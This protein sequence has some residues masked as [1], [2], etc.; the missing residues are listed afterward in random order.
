MKILYITLEDLS[1]HKGS[2][3][4]IKEI[5][6]GFRKRGHQVGLIGSS[7]NRSENADYFY[8]LK[9]TDHFF[10]KWLKNRKQPLFISSITLFLYLLRVLARYDLIYARD[11]H[12]VI[13][14]LISRFI[15]GKKL[16]FEI[17]GIAH[18]EQRLKGDT[19]LNRIFVFLIK[20]AE[21]V[22]SNYSDR[23]VSVTPQIA[24]Y[25]VRH[26]HTNKDKIEFISNGVNTRKF[27][28]IHDE[29]ILNRKR[30]ELGITVDEM[31]ITFVGN[32][33]PW[34]GVDLLIKAAPLVIEKIKSLKFLI[35]GDG[36]LR[37]EYE[38][39]VKHLGL[40]S[41]IIFTGMLEYELIPLI[42]NLSDI[43]VL[44]KRSMKSGFSPIKLYE[45]MACGKPILASRVEGM[46][47]IEEEG[48]GR[49]AEPG[50]VMDFSKG[51]IELLKD[52]KVRNEMGQKGLCLA[53]NRYDWN[54]KV[55]EIENIM[56]KLV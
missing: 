2:V 54:N 56:K 21:R 48:I 38:Q 14:S 44:P 4:H 6:A 19:I 45:Y 7:C 39:E 53:R 55:V 22:A 25:L 30:I 12:T 51:L 50:D 49:L 46:K 28:P 47:L 16:I 8:N 9:N 13:I 27:Y 5:I 29:K 35:V 40:T 34:Q 18:E 17:N 31:V 1:L 42:I 43:C 3:I 36:I 15:Y 11:F 10:L 26:Y 37:H 32:L 23:I 52:G 41:R 20:N 33:A 24:D